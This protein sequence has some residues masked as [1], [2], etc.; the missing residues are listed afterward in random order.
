M[1]VDQQVY[2]IVLNQLRE[3]AGYDGISCFHSYSWTTIDKRRK[4]KK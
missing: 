1:Q 2:T 4:K 3:A